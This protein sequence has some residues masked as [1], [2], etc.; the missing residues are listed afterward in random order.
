MK[1]LARHLRQTWHHKLPRVA[2]PWL[3]VRMKLTQGQS[4]D[5]KSILRQKSLEV[6]YRRRR[7]FFPYPMPEDRPLVMFHPWV[8]IQSPPQG[9]VQTSQFEGAF[10]A[11][12]WE[13]WHRLVGRLI[14]SCY[15]RKKY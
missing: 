2:H 11:K 13:C 6:H 9:R 4:Q 7:P 12:S 1:D 5:S 8:D 14:P 10:Q 15:T 3:L